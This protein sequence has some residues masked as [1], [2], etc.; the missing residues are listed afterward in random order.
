[1][2]K[3]RSGKFGKVISELKKSNVKYGS[4]LQST[5]SQISDLQNSVSNLENTAL[6]ILEKLRRMERYPVVQTKSGK[7]LP[8]KIISGS[9]SLDASN[10]PNIGDIENQTSKTILLK[11]YNFMLRNSE[12]EKKNRKIE[13]SKTKERK[14]E[15]QVN[16]RKQLIKAGLDP[17]FFKKKKGLI[18]KVATGLK[19]GVLGAIGL[20]LSGLVWLFSDEIKKFADS[21]KTQFEGLTSFLTEKFQ[22][23][24]SAF[25]YLRGLFAPV[26]EWIQRTSQGLM[27]SFNFNVG[28]KGLF[29]T[30]QD[31]VMRVV[32]SLLDSLVDKIT[33]WSVSIGNKIQSFLTT[34]LPWETY[35]AVM[36]TIA[37]GFVAGP[38][39]AKAFSTMIAAKKAS[40]IAENVKYYASEKQ[41][42]E[43][44]LSKLKEIIDMNPKYAKLDDESKRALI[45][46]IIQQLETGQP[47]EDL[48]G[49]DKVSLKEI[50][51]KGSEFDFK[52]KERQAKQEQ[53]LKE[54]KSQNTDNVKKIFEQHGWKYVEPKFGDG[55]PV[56]MYKNE[57]TGEFIMV[58]QENIREQLLKWGI[59]GDLLKYVNQT[60][61]GIK[62]EYQPEVD[63]FGN[64]IKETEEFLSK[65]YEDFKSGM[66]LSE[67]AGSAITA[68]KQPYRGNETLGEN[69]ETTA[70]LIGGG[71]SAG[72][73]AAAPLVSKAA[74]IDYLGAME[75][76][77]RK[78][79]EG[80]QK[81]GESYNQ[82]FSTWDKTADFF[83]KLVEQQKSVNI[84]A[85]PNGEG[86]IIDRFTNEI[87]KQINVN[88]QVVNNTSSST[89]EQL[90]TG[91]SVRNL[92]DPFRIANI[93]MWQTVRP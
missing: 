17:K 12:D 29:E 1:M 28:D 27:K 87:E 34:G 63:A 59:K 71:I 20:G 19:W 72:A 4:E 81:F 52:D 14:K 86:S 67:R 10:D 15:R 77:Y 54:W 73:K 39:G 60:V 91:I 16:Y 7:L 8:P 74:S 35:G 58:S 26:T 56:S 47:P 31:N 2:A 37:A 65:S 43:N 78:M 49:V 61:E 44:S 23:V 40:D 92:Y 48:F 6:L 45:N 25:N 33:E 57:Q 90:P 88:N 11:L 62:K 83:D 68:I 18:G 85:D 55:P 80:F 22:I 51:G 79:S 66:N 3:I 9:A 53:L 76:A 41:Y 38:F 42:G 13:N 5:G 69:L 82:N 30:I 46:N 84:G 50:M 24:T 32:N 21:L 64:K 93:E 89:E 70:T 36:G 75:D